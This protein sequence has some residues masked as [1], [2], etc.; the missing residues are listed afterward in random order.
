MKVICHIL[1]QMC[2]LAPKPI[3]VDS[4]LQHILLCPVRHETYQQQTASSA[5]KRLAFYLPASP[6]VTAR[7]PEHE[8]AEP[9]AAAGRDQE[10]PE[11]RR[12]GADGG[13][14][15]RNVSA[16]VFREGWRGKY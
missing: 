6:C 13:G 2:P 16:T 15:E 11:R 8:Q 9:G 5:K 14:V 3:C 4:Y 1:S 10:A 12:S 7:A